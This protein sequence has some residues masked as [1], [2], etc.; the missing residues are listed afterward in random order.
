MILTGRGG[1]E[2]LTISP[3]LLADLFKRG[4]I[5]GAARLIRARQRS[6]GDHR[7]A[8]RRT[9]LWRTAGTSARQRRARCRRPGALASASSAPAAAGASGLGRSGSRDPPRDGRPDRSLDRPGASGGRVLPAREPDGTDASGD[10]ARH[11][12]DA[13]VR[14]AARHAGAAPVLGRRRDR[15]AAPRASASADDGRTREVAAAAKASTRAF[16]D[17]AW[18]SAARRRRRTCSE[19]CWTAKPRRHGPVFG[20]RAHWSA[21]GSCG[22]PI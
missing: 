15:A 11:G 9:L 19:A 12:R 10:H 13:G 22:Q 8:R 7:P 2:W 17:S 5:A 20:G 6:T 1:D 3:Y 16:P 14:A 4:D 18:R 21:S